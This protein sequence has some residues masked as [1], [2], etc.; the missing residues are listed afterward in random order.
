MAMHEYLVLKEA[1]IADASDDD[2]EANKKKIPIEFEIIFLG[3]QN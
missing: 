1:C 2:F 3:F